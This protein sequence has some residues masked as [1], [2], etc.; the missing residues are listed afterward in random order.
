MKYLIALMGRIDS[1]KRA[2]M[3]RVAGRCF[4][5]LACG[6]DWGISALIIVA[7]LTDLPRAENGFSGLLV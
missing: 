3:N 6:S 2:V 4:E 5:N 7:E 1:S